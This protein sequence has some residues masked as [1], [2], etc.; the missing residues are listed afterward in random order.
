M[1]SLSKVF[2]TREQE[3]RQATIMLGFLVG[4]IAS[5]YNVILERHGMNVLRAIVST[6]H[7]LMKLILPRELVRF[8]VIRF[9]PD[10]V[11]LPP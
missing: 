3:P 8:E 9:W 11:M 10:S 7:L 6:Y 2:M 5:A 1:L 4:N